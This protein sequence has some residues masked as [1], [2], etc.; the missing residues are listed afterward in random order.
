MD[1][2]KPMRDANRDTDDEIDVERKK[3]EKDVATHY[4][5]TNE[6]MATGDDGQSTSATI[7]SF[8]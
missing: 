3:G 2:D 4:L 8:K 7:A 1:R 5:D 6:E